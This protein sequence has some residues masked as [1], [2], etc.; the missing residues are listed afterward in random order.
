MGIDAHLFGKVALGHGA[1]HLLGGLGGRQI[2]RIVGELRLQKPHP[3]GAAGGKHGPAVLAP[4]GKPLNELA[5]LLHDGQIGGEVGVEHVVEA[6]TLQSSYQFAYRHLLVFVYHTEHLCPGHPYGGGHLDHSGDLRVRQSPQDL[7]G[8]IP[9]RQ[10]AGGAMGDAL[11]AEHAGSVFQIAVIADIHGGAG[12]GAGHIP[13]VHP[14]DLVADLDAAHALDALA[15]LPDDGDA[16]VY[17]GTLRLHV[18]GLVMDVQVMGKLLQLAVAAADAGGT[19]GAVLGQDQPQVG[20]ARLPHPGGVGPDDHALQHLRVAGGDQAVHTLNLHHTHAAGGDL[21]DLFQKAQMG[22]GDA[23]LP[24]GIQ[25][26]RALWSGQRPV[27]DLEVYHF[28]TRP[29]LKIP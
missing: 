9:D 21:V 10:S 20:L 11:A 27:V 19:V 16:Q 22:N 4:V 7:V 17:A 26:G 29:P 12:A 14:L 23:G 25:D 6:Q 15:G 3:A 1:E 13:D 8:V 2:A 28:S 24:G 18:V 5:A